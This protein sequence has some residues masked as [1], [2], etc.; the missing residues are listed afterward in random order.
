MKDSNGFLYSD[1]QNKANI[2]NDQF[3]SVFTVED[4]T[5]SPDK[6][7]S[8]YKS[9]KDIQIT[10]QGVLKLLKNKKPLKATGPDEIPAFI[11]RSGAEQLASILTKIYQYSLDTGEVPQD[12]RDAL[13]V[14]IF[15]KGERHIPANYRPV[16]LTSITCKILEHIIHSSIM[17]HYD[18]NKILTDAQH[19][20]RNKRSCETQLIVT[21]TEIAKRLTRGTQVDIIL[22]D[23]TKAFGKVPHR[24]LLHKLSY[25][26]VNS[27]TTRWVQSFLENRNQQV[28]LEGAKSTSAP[29]MSG[30]PQGSVLGPLLFLTYINDMPDNINHSE[31]RL[32]ADD[33]ILFRAISK[34]SDSQLLQQD[35]SALE[36]WEN[37]WQMAFNPSKCTVIRVT[38]GKTNPEL[39]F[40]YQ[41][42][43]HTLEIEDASKYLGV[44]ISSNLSWDKHVDNI[45][46]KG[47]KTLGFIR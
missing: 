9:M 41:L 16:S 17:K 3:K 31:T 28:V 8:P 32:F 27:K 10:K 7:P 35:L 24:R 1:N 11:L 34:P 6:G 47:N 4:H 22:L 46:A 42:H 44:T 38:S 12:W 23:F 40:Q 14:P 37:R 29:V 13:V 25:Y 15:K 45:V 21:I 39:D 30:V 36:T 43:G 20:F 33:T 5:S 2:L 26:G 19:G 18:S